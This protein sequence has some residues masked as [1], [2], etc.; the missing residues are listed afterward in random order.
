MCTYRA[1]VLIEPEQKGVTDYGDS[2]ATGK[3]C[4]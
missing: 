3:I 1:E 2:Y 4:A